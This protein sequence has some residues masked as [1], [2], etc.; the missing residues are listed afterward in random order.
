[1][2]IQVQELYERLNKGEN[3]L[4]LDVRE[5]WEYDEENLNGKLIPLGELPHRLAEIEDWKDKEVIV[6][7]R[8]GGRS[9]NAKKF[10]QSKGFQNV[11]NLLGGISKYLEIYG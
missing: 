11:R 4:I 10:L 1:M 7:C 6:H 3:L 8:S 5:Q 2:D 9:E